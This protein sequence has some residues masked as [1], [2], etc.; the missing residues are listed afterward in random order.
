VASLCIYDGDC[1][2]CSQCAS[3]GARRSDVRFEPFQLID[4]TTYGI[5]EEAAASA[6]HWVGSDGPPQAGG[7]PR[8]LRGAAAVAAVLRECRGGWPMVGVVMRL[9]GI[10]TVAEVV[11]RWIAR[12]RYRLPGTAACSIEGPR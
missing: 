2:F 5:T 7:T 4:L 9:P 8:V 3:W 6:V 10:R 1:G 12:N 11:Y